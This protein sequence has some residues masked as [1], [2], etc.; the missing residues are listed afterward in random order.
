MGENV[1]ILARHGEDYQLSEAL[2]Q[3][4]LN[5]VGEVNDNVEVWESDKMS[6]DEILR[7]VNDQARDNQLDTYV[8]RGNSDIHLATNQ[9]NSHRTG[10]G[11]DTWGEPAR[12]P[13]IWAAGRQKFNST[14][15]RQR[16]S[17]KAKGKANMAMGK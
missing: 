8:Q 2:K 9:V 12:T 3:V 14:T 10:Q 4:A 16:T 6:F 15:T 13:A 11:S 5:L 7:R 1:N 17:G